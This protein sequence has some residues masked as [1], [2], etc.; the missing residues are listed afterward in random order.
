[1]KR[2]FL[3]SLVAACAAAFSFGSQ[4]GKSTAIRLAN[5]SQAWRPE[6]LMRSD[7]GTCAST[8]GRHYR[9][10]QRKRRKAWRQAG[11]FPVRS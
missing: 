7:M 3:T 2:N 11:C 8:F 4:P 5:D 10:N 6:L 9:A 1:M